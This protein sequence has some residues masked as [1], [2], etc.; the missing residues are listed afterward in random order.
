MALNK[1]I[2]TESAGFSKHDQI[3]VYSLDNTAD[4][5]REFAVPLKT[6]SLY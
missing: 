1:Y 4:E 5:V 6:W 2:R 3:A